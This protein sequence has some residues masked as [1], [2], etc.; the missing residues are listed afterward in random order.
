MMKGKIV[1]ILICS[2]M[3]TTVITIGVSALDIYDSQEPLEPIKQK[4]IYISRAWAQGNASGGRQIGVFGLIGI[5]DFDYVR[6]DKIRFNPIRW[7][8]VDFTDVKVIMFWLSQDIPSEG[9]FDFERDWVSAIV[10]G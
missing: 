10:L 9:P 1:G 3:V 4:A 6:F 7:E 5:I 2:L 8:M